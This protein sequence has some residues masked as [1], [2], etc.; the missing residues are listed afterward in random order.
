M[1]ERIK[2]CVK[3]IEYA[4]NSFNINAFILIFTF[5]IIIYNISIELY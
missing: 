1:S 2:W 5:D 4:R 3:N